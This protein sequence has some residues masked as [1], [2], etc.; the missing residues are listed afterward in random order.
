MRSIKGFEENSP[1][2]NKSISPKKMILISG[3]LLGGVIIALPRIK[4]EVEDSPLASK[5]KDA[6]VSDWSD[7]SKCKWKGKKGILKVGG[8][9]KCRT[10]TIVEPAVGE[11][12]TPK[13]KE[14]K[15]CTKSKLNPFDAEVSSSQSFMTPFY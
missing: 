2:K 15:G 14:C 7:W 10:R 6:V 11:G 8:Y 13:L 3:V 1:Y 12:K 9:K 4:A 5:D